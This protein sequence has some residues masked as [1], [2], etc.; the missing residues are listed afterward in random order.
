LND[1][2]PDWKVDDFG[3][4]H[5]FLAE[6][7]KHGLCEHL[8]LTLHE[9]AAIRDQVNNEMKREVERVRGLVPQPGED[10][11]RRLLKSMPMEPVFVIV[12]RRLI[13]LLI[14]RGPAASA[15]RP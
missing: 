10:A 5:Q 1:K 3:A 15:G 4:L 11:E 13:R 8:T 7:R 6:A 2:S 14:D 9:E 12:L